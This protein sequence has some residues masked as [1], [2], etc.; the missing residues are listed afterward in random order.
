MPVWTIPTNVYGTVYPE[1]PNLTLGG[2]FDPERDW[3][4][5]L[6]TTSQSD[7][8]FSIDGSSGATLTGVIPYRKLRSFVM[9]ALGYAYATNQA[10]FRMYR[11]NPPTHPIFPWLRVRAVTV[12]GFGPG[13]L[14]GHELPDPPPEYSAD[15]I[16]LPN[17]SWQVYPFGTNIPGSQDY[18]RVES[19]EFNG[20][21][22]DGDDENLRQPA[23]TIPPR[24]FSM[25]PRRAGEDFTLTQAGV[26]TG[27]ND[28][29][30]HPFALR[31]TRYKEAKVVVD[32]HQPLWNYVEDTEPGFNPLDESVRNV[33]WTTE[34]ALDVVSLEGGQGNGVF[35]RESSS[36]GPP[37]A[38]NIPTTGNLSVDPPNSG[39][40]APL[41][42]LE[43]KTMEVANWM[44]VPQRFIFDENLT[45]TRMLQCLGKV[46]QY[47]WYGWAPGTALLLA[48]SLQPVPWPVYLV[49][50]TL[51]QLWNVKYHFKVFDPPRRLNDWYDADPGEN[52]P[53]GWRV[54]RYLDGVVYHA[55]RYNG[56][57]LYQ[58]EDFSKLFRHREY[59]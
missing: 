42:F 29:G 3:R 16:T 44:H 22:L 52:P 32:F 23:A 28:R 35:W 31:T 34:P 14:T 45:P 37:K 55:T 25:R 36:T 10:P 41:G 13:R 39:F 2:V 56:D 4:E 15:R 5:E 46:N 1:G 19:L 54:F 24:M 47:Q 8:H 30:Y 20:D 11:I 33:F 49:D 58:Q 57:E 18:N 40:P 6:D 17:P 27:F 12:R 26:T 59:V 7:A 38:T 43:P 21:H 9:Y 50:F 48:V 51:P 53:R